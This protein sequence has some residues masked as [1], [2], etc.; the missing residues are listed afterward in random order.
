MKCGAGAPARVYPATR[1]WSEMGRFQKYWE[2]WAVR[3]RALPHNNKG[4]R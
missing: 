1:L 3:E 2:P 4:L